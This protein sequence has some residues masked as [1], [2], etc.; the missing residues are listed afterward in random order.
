LKVAFVG[1]TGSGANWEGVANLIKNEG[2][3]G[4]VVQ[5]DMSYAD[6]PAA[7]WTTTE[8]VLG[9]TFPIFISRGNHDDN[10]WASYLDKANAHLDGA[11]R[12]A[13]AHDANYKTTWRGLVIAT[14][15]KGDTAANITPFLQD[16]DHIWKICNW[17]QNQ[18][19][20]QLGDKADEMGWDVYEA[21]R[22]LGAIIQT[23]HEHS[24]S[25]T[26][27]LTNITTQTV[28]ATCN[29]PT[30]LCVSPGRTFLQVVGLGGQSIRD[31]K[32]CLPTVYPYGCNGEWASISTSNQGAANG[33]QFITFNTGGDPKKAS[34]YFKN[35]NG[36]M[37]DTF[38]V[39]YG[40]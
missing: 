4:L 10:T 15:K 13:G 9:T 23:G 20:L 27:T 19:A 22:Q 12:V 3:N 5:G 26:K 24:Y 34:G 8:L 11:T 25:R 33:A 7:W 28:D 21:C 30:E 31:Q 1:D 14:I 16:E 32:R 38:N 36:Q 17:H 2:A 18:T 37:V 6:D 29:S 39:T 35:V 40:P